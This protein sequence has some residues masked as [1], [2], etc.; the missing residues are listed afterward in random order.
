MISTQP[1]VDLC[2]L[3]GFWREPGAVAG[4]RRLVAATLGSA[5]L[6]FRKD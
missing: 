5:F 3:D 4:R 1:F 6:D 2:P